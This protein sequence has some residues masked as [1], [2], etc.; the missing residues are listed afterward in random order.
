MTNGS[1]SGV[2]PVF[3]WP[4]GKRAALSL[5]FDDSRLSQVDRA[6]PILD[7]HGVKGSFY[8]VPRNV[9]ARLDGWK[10]A[11]SA[12]HEI[13]NHTLNHPCSANFAFARLKPLEDY[14]LK[15]MEEELTR[16]NDEIER[17]LGVRPQTFAYPCA[18]KFVGRGR[19]VKSYVPLVARH[20]VVGRDAHSETHNHP[21]YCD[22]AQVYAMGAD[23]TELSQLQG[24]AQMA[25]ADGGWL[26]LHAHEVGEGG[27]QTMFARVLDE[28]CAWLIAPD[29]GLWADTV[30]AVGRHI[31]AQRK[32]R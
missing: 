2:E 1:S 30:E 4:T 31:L 25:L 28:F 14:T 8:V 22:L 29:S 18:Q 27:R 19:Q 26:I 32:K 12:G 7:A 16:S 24:L 3:N 5:T 11:V 20:F 10:N 6:L 15:R 23:G 21:V 13:G 17:L 9:A